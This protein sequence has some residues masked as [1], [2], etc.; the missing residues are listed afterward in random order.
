M[1]HDCNDVP[2]PPPVGDVTVWGG[3]TGGEEADDEEEEGG[4]GGGGGW[5]M[6]READDDVD[7]A[8]AAAT[9]TFVRP[10]VLSL[11]ILVL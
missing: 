10:M 1:G 8:G 6:P 9:R 5:A 4:G 3:E 7:V 2:P 11:S